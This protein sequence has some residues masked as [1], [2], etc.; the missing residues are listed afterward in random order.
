[1][2]QPTRLHNKQPVRAAW[3][4][5]LHIGAGWHWASL[6][7]LSRLMPV[8]HRLALHKKEEC[9]PSQS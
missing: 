3:V 9:P 4:Q 6:A 1:M 7:P 2:Q 5:L 8:S